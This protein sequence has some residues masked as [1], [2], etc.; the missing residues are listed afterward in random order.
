MAAPPVG[1]TIRS[2]SPWIT[3]VGAVI[4]RSSRR[5]VA[6]LEDRAELAADAARRRVAVPARP[7]RL[8]HPGLVE[9]EAVRADVPEHLSRRVRRPLRGTSAASRPSAARSTGPGGRSRRAPVVDMI[10]VRVR[11]R[12]G[13]SAA[14]VW[15]IMPPIDTPATWADSM[16]SA[17]S[18]P[19]VSAAMSVEVVLLRREAAGEHRGQARRPEARVRRAA[20]VAVVEPD[21]LGSPRS[22]SCAQNASGQLCSCWPSPATSSSGSAAGV[23]DPFVGQGDAPADV[24][25]LFGHES[26]SGG[27]AG[28]GARPRG[29]PW[30]ARRRR[31]ANASARPARVGRHEREVPQQ[32][33]Q[34]DVHL[35]GARTRRRGSAGCRRR[36]GSTGRGPGARRRSG[37]GRRWPR[38][39]NTA[40]SSWIRAML[41]STAY[42]FGSVQRPS[43]KPSAA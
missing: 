6:G 38:R 34:H 12:A 16:S 15:A 41:T 42:P 40:S 36:T 8:A 5:P 4:C 26:P 27:C 32:G 31:P 14:T 24:G 30:R 39:G 19:T 7:G 11:T 23:P 3:S 17:S 1:W 10:D 25:D 21:D 2:R 29:R 35:H 43:W 37:A 33:P 20:G 13:C 9:G 28:G 22:A 18:S